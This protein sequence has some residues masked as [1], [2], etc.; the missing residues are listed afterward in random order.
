[1]NLAGQWLYGKTNNDFTIIKNAVQAEKFQYNQNVRERVR[2]EFSIESK[3][4]LGHIGRFSSQK[5]HLFLL[6]VF[7]AV[8]EQNP[9]TVLLLVGEGKLRERIEKKI[10][11]LGLN[12]NVILTGVRSDIPELLQA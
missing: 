3:L 7:K 1:S 12:D 11:E 10:N 4:V 9:N 8:Y 6:E 2:K 5:N